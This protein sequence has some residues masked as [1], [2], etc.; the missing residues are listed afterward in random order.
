MGYFL[1][2][3]LNDAHVALSNPAKKVANSNENKADTTSTIDFR[4]NS[5]DDD[6]LLKLIPQT[7]EEEFTELN[8]QNF[9]RFMD[10]DNN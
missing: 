5:E 2:Y 4:V 6:E 7:V 1:A 8:L 3:V 10:Q 9:K